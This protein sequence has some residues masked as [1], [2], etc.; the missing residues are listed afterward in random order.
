MIDQ[1][2]ELEH[3]IKNQPTNVFII[4]GTTSPS[5][6]PTNSNFDPNE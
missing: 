4:K 5:D 1:R 3:N 2:K 6:V